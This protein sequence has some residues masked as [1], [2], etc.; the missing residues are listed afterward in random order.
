MYKKLFNFYK[1]DLERIEKKRSNS[2][3]VYVEF[4]TKVQENFVT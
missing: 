3:L 2:S 1:V 4:K